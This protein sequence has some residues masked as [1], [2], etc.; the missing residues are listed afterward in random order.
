MGVELTKHSSSARQLFDQ[1]AE[2]LGMDLLRLCQAGPAEE[3]NRTEFCQPALYVHSLAALAELQSQREGLWDDVVAVAGLSLGEYTAIAAAGGMSF[4]DGLKLV[5]ARGQAMQA[6]ADATSSGM[7]SILGLDLEILREVCQ[8]AS[9]NDLS[10][11]QP[12]NLL[13]PGNIAISGH[14]DAMQRAEQLAVERGAMKAVRLPVAGAF[15]TTIMQPAAE[16]LREALGQVTFSP[17]RVP[18]YSNVDCQPHLRPEEFS[19]LLPQQLVAPVRWEQ[20]L[21][22]LIAAGVDSFIEV[23]AG[24]VLAGTVKRVNRKIACECFGENL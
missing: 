24:R 7:S 8:Q 18:V 9:R 13:C 10:F 14:L 19:S 11:V 23:G 6:A 1:A 20:S 12:A 17:T 15:H 16:R 2:T 22:E 21:V 5:R 4:T 3:L